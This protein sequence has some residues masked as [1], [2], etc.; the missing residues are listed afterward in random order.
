MLTADYLRNVSLHFPLTIDVNHVGAA[1]FFNPTA[2][3]N[4]IAATTSGFGCGGGTDAAAI[5]CS[6]AAGATIDDFAG[7]GLDSGLAYLS[8]A[9]AAAFGLTTDTG[10]AFAGANPLMGVGDFEYPM[11]RSVYNALQMEFKQSEANPFRYADSMNLQVAYSLSRFVG[12]GGNDQ[13]FSAAAWDND[14]PTRYIGPTSLDRLNQFKF[15]W[16]VQSCITGRSSASSRRSL[17]RRRPR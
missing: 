14:N 9:P 4:A 3:A 11:G 15:G 8:G 16:T 7:H 12:N 1:R 13:N 10:A 17:Q 2:A 6:I 5:N